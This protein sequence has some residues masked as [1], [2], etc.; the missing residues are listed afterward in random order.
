MCKH[1]VVYACC[2][3]SRAYPCSVLHRIAK[4]I[5]FFGFDTARSICGDYGEHSICSFGLGWYHRRYNQGW[6]TWPSASA[7]RLALGHVR[8]LLVTVRLGHVQ[9]GLVR[10]QL[11][12]T[13]H[14]IAP[15]TVHA[16]I[17]FFSTDRLLFHGGAVARTLGTRCIAAQLS[18]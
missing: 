3:P 16:G 8:L 4:T 12:P 5:P 18:R 7:R 13:I 2:H 11:V 14:S 1:V 10:V 6:R 17:G 15:Q 9:L